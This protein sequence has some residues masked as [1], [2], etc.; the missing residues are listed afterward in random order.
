MNLRVLAERIR[1][2]GG[3][4]E[5]YVTPPRADGGRRT[6][7]GDE[8]TQGQWEELLRL[9]RRVPA[10]TATEAQKARWRALRAAERLRH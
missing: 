5:S 9:M 7:W 10:P 4:L 1:R 8:L 3:Y 6:V 2:E